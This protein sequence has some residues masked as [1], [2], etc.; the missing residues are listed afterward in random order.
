[1]PEQSERAQEALARGLV[2]IGWKEY[3]DFPDWH[4]RHVRAKIDTG[5]YSSA[6]DVCHYE[7]SEAP[8]GGLLATLSLALSRRHPERLKRVQVPVLRMVGV[9][10]SGGVREER[11]LI[12]TVIRLGPVFKRIRLTV[13]DRSRMRHRM[14]LGRQALAG[15]F[16]VDVSQKYLQKNKG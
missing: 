11:P 10:N 13:T 2:L 12:E 14:L 7:L 3:L 8:G 16:L 5:A 1:M 15:S 9:S 6:L 4:L